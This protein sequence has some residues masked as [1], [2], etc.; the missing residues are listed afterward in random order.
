MKKIKVLSTTTCPKCPEVTN[1][2][3]TKVVGIST[4][5]ITEKDPWFASQCKL[6]NATQAPTV[7]I[8]GD[9]DVELGRANDLQELKVLLKKVT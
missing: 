8:F 3:H 1:Y 7:I 5:F 4:E 6:Y 2:L 9:E